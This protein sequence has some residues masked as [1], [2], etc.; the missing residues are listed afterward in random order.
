MSTFLENVS[1]LRF[2]WWIKNFLWTELHISQIYFL[3]IPSIP[4]IWKI[5]NNV[6]EKRIHTHTNTHFFVFLVKRK[7]NGFRYREWRVSIF[8]TVFDIKQWVKILL[9]EHVSYS[10]RKFLI[11]QNRKR[12]LYTS[13]LHPSWM[14]CQIYFRF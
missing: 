14:F 5:F 3:F 7:L 4:I 8:S 9:I 11:L 1:S 2:I 6:K 10:L 13:V 12:T